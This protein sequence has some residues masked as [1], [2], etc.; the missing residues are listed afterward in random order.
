MVVV[1]VLAVVVLVQPGRMLCLT[2]G[3]WLARPGVWFVRIGGYASFDQQVF[4]VRLV[5]Y[6]SFH[7]MVNVQ[8]RISASEVRFAA[9]NL[10]FNIGF[11]TDEAHWGD[12]FFHR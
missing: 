8:L 12:Y 7:F 11:F 2:R 10:F 4:F 9:A 6:G 3:V 1:V 5:G